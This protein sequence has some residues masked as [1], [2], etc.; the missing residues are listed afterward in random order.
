MKEMFIERIRRTLGRIPQS[1]LKQ[2]LDSGNVISKITDLSGQTGE[3]LLN[4]II[5]NIKK[6]SDAKVVS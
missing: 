4:T 2:I 3:L 1:D 6:S 5:M